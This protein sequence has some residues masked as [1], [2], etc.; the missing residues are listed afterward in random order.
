MKVVA[1]SRSVHHAVHQI[2]ELTGD[3]P[4]DQIL[5]PLCWLHARSPCVNSA[6]RKSR[7][8]QEKQAE[9]GNFCGGVINESVEISANRLNPE[10]PWN[11]LEPFGT[12][13]NLLEPL[14]TLWNPLEPLLSAGFKP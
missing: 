8:F 14:G 13:W 12:F 10:N 5:D 9:P 6:C 4:G 7:E 1:H 11:L 2:A 3:L